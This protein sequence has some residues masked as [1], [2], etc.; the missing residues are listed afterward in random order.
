LIPSIYPVPDGAEIKEVDI[1]SAKFITEQRGEVLVVDG[2]GRITLGEGSTTLR[3]L[4]RQL[5]KEGH[6]KFILG[7]AE[8]NYIDSSGIGEM[9]SGY[10]H[11][12]ING[13]ELKIAALN[14]RC[15]DLLQITKLY[16]KF[17]VH[18][19]VDEAV[20]CFENNGR[21]CSY[22]RL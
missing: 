10:T 1:M 9:V 4:L 11:V 3:D 5:V 14:K 20:L 12:Q 6:R 22:R 13:G 17:D 21:T 18:E 16:S 7:V 15:R 19:T 8:I 2:T